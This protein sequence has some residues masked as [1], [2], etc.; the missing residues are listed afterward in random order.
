MN[1]ESNPKY[2]LITGASGGIGLELARVFAAR[3][4]SLILTARSGGKLGKLKNEL[5]K[6]YSIR[7][8]VAITDLAQPGSAVKLCEEIHR[9]GF[10]VEGLVN[11]AGFGLYGH[12]VS[13]SLEEQTQMIQL[14]IISLTELTRIFLPAMIQ[15]KKGHIL[16]VA[17]TAAFQAGPLMAVY[18]AT[19]A[20]VLY[21]SEAI[22]NELQ[23]T[24]VKVSALCPGPTISDFQSRASMNMKIPLF[25]AARIMDAASVARVGYNGL[26]K[27]KRVI[28]PGLMNKISS[29]GARFFPREFLTSLVRRLQ[30]GKD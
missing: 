29:L 25:K 21:F 12:F 16:N 13:L 4:H 20:Y 26:M 18:Y 2:T 30:E 8:E 5:E 24:G 19:K 27:N 14:N 22:A 10:E 15:Q 7:A 1:P 28:L 17:S 9:R 3:G 11:N 23:G 6:S